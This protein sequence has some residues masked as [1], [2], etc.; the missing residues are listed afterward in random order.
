MT[1]SA[2]RLIASGSRVDRGSGAAGTTG[3]VR[4]SV[5]PPIHTAVAAKTVIAFWDRRIRNVPQDFVLATVRSP[6]WVHD[7]AQPVHQGRCSRDFPAQQKLNDYGGWFLRRPVNSRPRN[8]SGSYRPSM[9]S[10]NADDRGGRGV[11]RVASEGVSWSAA[12]TASLTSASPGNSQPQV[13]GL[14]R[15][16]T[17]PGRHS[18][19]GSGTQ[20][21]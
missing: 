9:T 12:S 1:G 5:P 18:E 15:Q 20:P 16:C 21:P 2:G 8:R 4:R 13:A 6:A 19:G 7:G 11:H 17:T 10:L 14:T 3:Q